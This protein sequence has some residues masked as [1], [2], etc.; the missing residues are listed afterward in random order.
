MCDRCNGALITRRDDEPAT[1]LERLATY[2]EQTEPLID[3]YRERGKLVVVKGQEKV[4]NTTRLLLAA[5]E[6]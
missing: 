3:F 1:V 4:E 5:L 6:A 2:H